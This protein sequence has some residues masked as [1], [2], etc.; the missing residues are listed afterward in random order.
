MVWGGEW[1]D[2]WG[3]SERGRCPFAERTTDSESPWSIA[4]GGGEKWQAGGGVVGRVRPTPSGPP[5]E[6]ESILGKSG[7]KG[8]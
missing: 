8:G 6:E 2:G 1:G 4:S 5:G 7:G 3:C